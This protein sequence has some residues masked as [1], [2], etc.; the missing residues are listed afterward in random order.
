[1]NMQRLPRLMARTHDDRPDW[2]TEIVKAVVL[3]I[4]VW[5]VTAWFN[6][7]E[8]TEHRFT[9]LES[10]STQLQKDMDEVKRDVKEILKTVKQ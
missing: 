6:G 8:A 4:A 9:A 10:T 2:T 7:R 1:M 5:A 3:A